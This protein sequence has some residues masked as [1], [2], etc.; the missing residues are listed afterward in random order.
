MNK[1]N[2]YKRFLAAALLSYS[3]L[4]VGKGLTNEIKSQNSSNDNMITYENTLSGTS[5][6]K[7]Y[8]SQNE[9]IESYELDK[10]VFTKEEVLQMLEEGTVIKKQYGDSPFCIYYIE[11]KKAGTKNYIYSVP[12]GYKMYA[13]LLGVDIDGQVYYQVTSYICTEKIKENV[14]TRTK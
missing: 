1:N 10:N 13:K 11:V 4:L 14:R 9:I 12:N 8:E 6:Q 7:L 3:I 5:V 2:Q